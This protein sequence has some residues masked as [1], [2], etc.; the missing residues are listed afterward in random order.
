MHFSTISVLTALLS[1]AAA[2]KQMQINYYDD[3]LCQ[4]FIG[5]VDVS[6]ATSITKGKDNCYNYSYGQGMLIAECQAGG[7]LCNLYKGQNCNTYIDQMRYGGS[8]IC[9]P[10]AGQVQSFACYYG[11]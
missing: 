5:Q 9:R 8:G 11:A 7:C 6:W 3:K 1:A 2:A 10:F 4:D